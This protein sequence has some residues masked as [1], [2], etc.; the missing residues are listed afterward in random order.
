M[1]PG[2]ALIIIRDHGPGDSIFAIHLTTVGV[3]DGVMVRAG[4]A[5]DLDLV[6]D[7][8]ITDTDMAIMDVAGGDPVFIIRHVGVAGTVVHI[9]TVSMEIVSMYTTMYM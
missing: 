9:P 7:M 4:L 2:T 6:T 5:L 8:V 3:L 1:H